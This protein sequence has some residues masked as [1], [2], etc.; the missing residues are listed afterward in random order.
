VIPLQREGRERPVFVF[1]AGHDEVTA[2]AIE[3]QVA[4]HV[5]RDRPFWGFGRD[6][7]QLDGARASGIPG[8]AAEY[9]AQMRTIQGEGPFLLYA[10]CAGG[11]YAWETAARLLA[12]GEGIAGML[13]YE[14]PLDPNLTAPLPHF[15]PALMSEPRMP[16]GYRPQPLPVALTLVMTEFWRRRRWSVAWRAV[17]LGG[18][19]IV[20][21]SDQDVSDPSRREARIAGH[22]RDWIERAEARPRDG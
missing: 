9:E 18:T 1:P 19:R 17:A 21:I 12:A 3:A 11:P 10:N 6:D 4:V 5:G 2:L 13:F 20:V 22:V 15:T 14:V 16:D 8:L 7:P